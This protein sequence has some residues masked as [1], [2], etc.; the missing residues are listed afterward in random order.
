MWIVD[1]WLKL[2][3]FC[4]I[5]GASEAVGMANWVRF[6]FL[7]REPGGGTVNWV[8]FAFSGWRDAG[9]G[10][11]GFVLRFWGWESR[12]DASGT[13]IGFVSHFL[14]RGDG[15]RGVN[16]VRFVCLGRRPVVGG[17]KLGSFR[18][19]GGIPARR[20]RARTGDWVRFA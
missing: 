5:G 13:V 16:W 14:V 18:I 19:F 11:I 10:Q 9:G 15:G 8:R 6:A 20:D 7:G 1:W 2:G 4:I 12:R 3:S 17:G